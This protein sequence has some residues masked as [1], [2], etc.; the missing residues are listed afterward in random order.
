M[1][2]ISAKD[3]L[4]G[5]K[6]GGVEVRVRR[7]DGQDDEQVPQHGEQVHGQEESKRKGWSSGSSE[8]QEEEFLGTMVRFPVLYSLGILETK[9]VEK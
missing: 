6:H 1:K 5:K 8:A 3:R 9:R 4:E 2:P 7:A